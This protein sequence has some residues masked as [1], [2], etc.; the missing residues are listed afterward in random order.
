MICPACTSP[1]ISV[2]WEA[3][4]TMQVVNGAAKY[5]LLGGF[6]GSLPKIHCSACGTYSDTKEM[7]ES[8]QESVDLMAGAFVKDEGEYMIGDNR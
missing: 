3:V 7:P 1:D 6:L 8:F 2:D 5:M 4:V